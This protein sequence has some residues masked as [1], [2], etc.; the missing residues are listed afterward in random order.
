MVTGDC[1]KFTGSAICGFPAS[2][3]PCNGSVGG[4]PGQACGVYLEFLGEVPYDGVGFADN[5]G[6][7]YGVSHTLLMPWMND[8]QCRYQWNHVD[9]HYECLLELSSLNIST[10]PITVLNTGGPCISEREIEE[11]DF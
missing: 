5:G 1:F 11:I 4:Q 10:C 8:G 3:A 2:V 6:A 7:G 9:L